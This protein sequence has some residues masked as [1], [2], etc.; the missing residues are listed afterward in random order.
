MDRQLAHFKNTNVEEKHEN[1][2]NSPEI[3]GVQTKP[4]NLGFCFFNMTSLV[5]LIVLGN[6]YFRGLLLK[7]EIQ[8]SSPLSLS[9]IL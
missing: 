2:Y 1:I 3:R 8:L 9:L 4:V 6:W 7:G 5:V